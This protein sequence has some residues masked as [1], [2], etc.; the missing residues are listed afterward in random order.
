MIQKIIYFY[1]LDTSTE[2]TIWSFWKK[3]PSPRCTSALIRSLS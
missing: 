3:D 2:G 1:L